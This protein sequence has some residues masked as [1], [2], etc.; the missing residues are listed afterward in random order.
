VLLSLRAARVPLLLSSQRRNYAKKQPP[1][2]MRVFIA[3]PL[4]R[5]CS[6]GRRDRHGVGK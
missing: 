6:R 5:V 3:G 1:Q 4:T 2:M